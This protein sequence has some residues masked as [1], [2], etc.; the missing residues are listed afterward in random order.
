MLITWN[1]WT[2]VFWCGYGD[3][4]QLIASCELRSRN[5]PHEPNRL[6]IILIPTCLAIVFLYDFVLNKN[7]AYRYK[8]LFLFKIGKKA[9][10]N[11]LLAHACGV[12]VRIRIRIRKNFGR[13]SKFL[14][15]FFFASFPPFF[16]RKLFFF[17]KL[18]EEK[19]FLPPLQL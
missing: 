7:K 18:W 13:I 15:S 11:A 3:E 10:F 12:G 6:T 14:Q 5:I 8:K 1:Y 9:A 19:S 17:F 16:L 4:V 2:S